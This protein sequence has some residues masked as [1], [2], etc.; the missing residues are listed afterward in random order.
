MNFVKH[1]YYKLRAFGAMRVLWFL[2]KKSPVVFKGESSAQQIC[3]EVAIFGHTKVLVVT[4]SF[5]AT[6]GL[7]DGLFQALQQH[8]IQYEIFDGVQPNPTFTAVQAGEKAFSD[9]GCEALIS[10]GGGSVLDAAKMI[11]LLHNNPLSLEGFEGVGKSKH[12]AVPHFAIP[13][14]AG[15]GAEITPVAVI[16]DPVSHRKVLITDGKMI[17]EFIA[18]DPLLMIGLPPS[19]TAATGMD[20]LTHA[21]EA[22]VSRGAIPSTDSEARAAIR[23]IFRYLLRAYQDGGDMEARDAMAVASFYAGKSFSVAGVGYVHAVA[24]HLGRVCGV[25]HGNANAMVLPEVL[26]AYG[27]CIHERLAE[28]ARLVG[29]GDQS[30]S[31]RALAL[32]FIGQIEDMREQLSLPLQVEQLEPTG[33]R[34]IVGEALKEAG[35]LYPVPRYL[36]VSV[37]D[38]MVNNLMP[39]SNR[40]H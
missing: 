13:T 6:S 17:P 15:T 24:H 38:G 11:A 8:S 32:K 27:S 40:S 7:L 16:S 35:N 21:V 10:V 3:G 31:D 20:A 4:D 39:S 19:I 25:P 12:A 37:L 34:S 9:G 28:L 29:L 5:L 2:P 1:W 36:E 23:L 18:L 30:E 26:H 33:A 22:Y 14:T